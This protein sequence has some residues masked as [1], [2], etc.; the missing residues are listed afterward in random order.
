MTLF[1]QYKSIYEKLLMVGKEYGLIHEPVPAEQNK[2]DRDKAEHIQKLKELLE[3][4]QEY[5]ED[6]EDIL[7]IVEPHITSRNFLNTRQDTTVRYNGKQDLL[8]ERELNFERLK[9]WASR[10][11]PM[12]ADDPYAQ[13]IYVQIICNQKYLNRKE[14][15]F[16]ERMEAI[17][18]ADS[19]VI[20]GKVKAGKKKIAEILESDEFSTFVANLTEAHK[21]NN[22]DPNET[23]FSVR[24]P[25][26]DAQA[27]LG[28]YVLPL[29]VPPEFQTRVKEKLG[30]CYDS[31]GEAIIFP[32]GQSISRDTIIVYSADQMKARIARQSFQ[33]CLFDYCVN[34]PVGKLRI[35]VLDALHYNNSWLGALKS[36][37]NTT[38]IEKIP[39]N[40]TDLLDALRLTVAEFTDIDEQLQNEDTVDEYNRNHEEHP[41]VRQLL[42]LI[43]YPDAFPVQARELVNRILVNHERYGITVLLY[44]AKNAISARDELEPFK[45]YLDATIIEMTNQDQTVMRYGS[46]PQQFRVYPAIKMIS[47]GLLEKL[48]DYERDN[49]DK[50]EEYQERVGLAVHYSRGRKEDIQVV[51]GVDQKGEIPPIS[52]RNENFA[53]F[54]M[55]ASGSG[56][57]TMLHVLVTYLIQNYHPDDVELWLADFKMSE[58]A[59][60]VNPMPPHIKYILLDESA[61]LVFDFINKLNEELQLRQR[62]FKT[63]GWKDIKDVTDYYLPIIF[64]IIDE[65]SIMSQVLSTNM[66]Y[67]QILQNILSKGRGLG[68]KF[69]FASQDYT[70][71]IGGLTAMAKDQIQRRIAMRNNYDEIRDTLDLRSSAITE[72]VRAWMEALPAHYAM[73]K[74]HETGAV[75]RLKTLF[76]AG[77]DAYQPQRQMIESLLLKME[78][79]EYT[80]KNKGVLKNPNAYINKHGLVIDGNTFQ[81]YNPEKLKKAAYILRQGDSCILPDDKLICPGRPRRLSEYGFITLSNE[82][83]EN[84][85]LIGRKQE[86]P[87]SVSIIASICNQFEQQGGKAY[88]LA[89]HRNQIYMMYR[90]ALN[91]STKRSVI[92]EQETI[93]NTLHEIYNEMKQGIPGNILIVILGVDR[94]FEGTEVGMQQR[95]SQS[96]TTDTTLQNLMASEEELKE[97]NKHGQEEA[98]SKEISEEDPL[99]LLAQLQSG[100]KPTKQKVVDLQPST[101]TNT[102]T[103]NQKQ[104][105]EEILQEGSQQGYHVLVCVEQYP[106][107]KASGLKQ[108]VFRHKMS[109]SVSDDD[110]ISVFGNKVASRIGQHVCQY[111][112]GTEGWSFRPYIHKEV[113]WD[114]W[115]FNEKTGEAVQL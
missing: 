113:Q 99:S 53:A 68:F 18:R 90:K 7:R 55:G 80:A 71:G 31:D 51:L 15:E 109:F 111:D 8:Q 75:S 69:V 11:D 4:I 25:S 58:F 56:K 88:I 89:F 5:R 92:T 47:A 6:L 14:K 26:E 64:V 106:E 61:E 73:V 57:S 16:R 23:T 20:P 48:K 59:Q 62:L 114:D 76:F 34:Y 63:K 83:R 39:G 96:S 110:S 70:K 103:I 35:R 95:A 24:M 42:V 46:K 94:I 9:R 33:R 84:I 67:M 38:L 66:D 54:L 105:L 82:R 104:E 2:D 17:E 21:K 100:K 87:C 29:L 49:R 101:P 3:R 50:G 13:R 22:V 98:N 43:G 65:F 102:M 12:N 60:Y 36:L 93:C 41:I 44:H 1:E 30:D 32:L 78:K 86:W 81:S 45:N 52:F 108:Q 77:K 74:E 72:Q 85:L 112:N 97:V 37:E 40:E 27:I 107:F 115:S 19:Y 79:T 28:C 10:I 91:A